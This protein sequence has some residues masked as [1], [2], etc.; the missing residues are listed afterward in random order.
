MRDEE[1]VSRAYREAPRALLSASQFKLFQSCHRRWGFRYLEGKKEPEG[2][3]ALEG[4][5]AHAE[6]EE[7]A[8]SGKMPASKMGLAALRYAPAP[9]LARVEQIVRVDVD[10]TSWIGFLDL[11]YAWRDGKPTDPREDYGMHV[12]HDWKFTSNLRNAMSPEELKEDTAA[13]LYS[14]AAYQNNAAKVD[15]RWIYTVR[16]DTTCPTKEV[17]VSM[18]ASDAIAGMYMIADKAK[19]TYM[20]REEFKKKRLK[21]LDLPHNPDYCFA[22]NAPC[23]YK[24]ECQPGG[25]IKMPGG[26]MTTQFQQHMAAQFPQTVPSFPAFPGTPAI[27]SFPAFPGAPVVP[28]LPPA[29]PI[30]TPPSVAAPAA[31]PPF[32]SFPSQP[33]A[34]PAAVPV[35]ESGFVNPPTAPSTPATSP[36][37]LAQMQAQQAPAAPVAL[38]DLD[39]MPHEALRA[40]ALQ[41][42]CID[43]AQ[44]PK[45]PTLRALI[46]AKRAEYA[47]GAPQPTLV[48]P[49]APV[50]P[51]V[52]QAE[53]STPSAI[54]SEA[55]PLPMLYIGCRPL[56][57]H[58]KGIST[59]ELVDKVNRHLHESHQDHPRD[60]RFIP[61]TAAAHFVDTA[62]ALILEDGYE[63]IYLDIRTPEGTLLINPLTALV[64]H[65]NVIV[66]Y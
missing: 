28:G 59:A 24:E 43:N 20:Y 12:V 4:T 13:I 10:D 40:L 17:R 18:S 49:T 46:R 6:M 25:K 23:T 42:G 16:S 61:Y 14:Y 55:T 21:V 32:P 26:D 9:G 3:A 2:R 34:A 15:C 44:R 33:V 58:P 52:Q 57:P 60:Y 38:D 22:F 8:L 30:P 7:W 64:G 31:P 36:E 19:P 66:A 53:T 35:V 51:A 48:A 37:H 63:E 29:A 41:M 39:A 11:L 45:D 50:V 54:P 27:P 47:A 5:A 65:M 56:T 62:K 1:A